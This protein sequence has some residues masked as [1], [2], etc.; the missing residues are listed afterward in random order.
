LGV[1]CCVQVGVL[2]TSRRLLFMDGKAKKCKLPLLHALVSGTVHK[3]CRLCPSAPL[4]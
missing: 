3:V 2:Y 4:A 1:L